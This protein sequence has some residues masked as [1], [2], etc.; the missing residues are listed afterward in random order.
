MKN[1][2]LVINDW[3]PIRQGGAVRF[4]KKRLIIR[5]STW[6]I[7]SFLL[8]GSNI[9]PF[10]GSNAKRQTMEW[11]LPT[12]FRWLDDSTTTTKRHFNPHP[13]IKKNYTNFY[14][15]RIMQNVRLSMYMLTRIGK[16]VII[17]STR[18]FVHKLWNLSQVPQSW[19]HTMHRPS[20]AVW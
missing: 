10:V 20:V 3:A 15:A 18:H 13:P 11:G 7:L 4:S 14:L 19:N 6:C 17:S 5:I 9:Q 16:E 1:L 12:F 2:C 8:S